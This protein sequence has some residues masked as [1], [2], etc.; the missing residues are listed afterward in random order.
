MEGLS[1]FEAETVQMAEILNVATDKSFFV[2]DEF[3]RGTSS[4]E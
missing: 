3:G 4:K 2:L 1:A